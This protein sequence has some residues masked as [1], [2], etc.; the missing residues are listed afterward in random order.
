MNGPGAFNYS[1]RQFK[2]R[3]E[4]G[5]IHVSEF[6]LI[7]TWG[8]ISSEALQLMPGIHKCTEYNKNTY[9]LFQVL[10]N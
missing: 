7:A 6:R 4:F 1:L 5:S 10:Y 9:T 2:Q 8:V 3:T